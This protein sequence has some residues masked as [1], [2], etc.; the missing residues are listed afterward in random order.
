MSLAFHETT[1]DNMAPNGHTASV[2]RPSESTPQ[3]NSRPDW[4]K[5]HGI[6]EFKAWQKE[7]PKQTVSYEEWSSKGSNHIA[8]LSLFY[9]ALS[10]WDEPDSSVSH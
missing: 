10:I 4:I 3:K 1:H 7:N 6:V 2:A 9:A 8:G 5:E